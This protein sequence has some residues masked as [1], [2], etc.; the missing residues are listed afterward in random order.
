MELE[1]PE[2]IFCPLFL[3]KIEKFSSKNW[4]INDLAI[5]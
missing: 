4:K 1:L 5:A 3:K 2:N